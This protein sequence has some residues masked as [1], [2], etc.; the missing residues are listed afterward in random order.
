MVTCPRVL[1]LYVYHSKLSLTTGAAV[2]SR[3]MRYDQG[4]VTDHT[5]PSPGTLDPHFFFFFSFIIP[6]T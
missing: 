6:K 2:W 1:D 4:H 3:G 5:A